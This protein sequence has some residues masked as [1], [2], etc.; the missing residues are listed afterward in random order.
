MFVSIVIPTYNRLE[1][2]KRAIASIEAQTYTNYELIIVDDASD[3]GTREYLLEL[4]HDAIVLSENQGVSHAR[5]RGAGL[6]QGE[7]IAFLDSDDCWHE[8]KLKEQVAFH[9]QNAEVKCSFG[10]E[11]WFRFKQQVKRPKKYHANEIV[12]FNDLLEFTFIGP[13]S[14]MIQ[15][16]I[17][18]SLKGFDENLRICEDFDLW[19]RLSKLTP[20]YLASAVTIYKHAGEHSQLSAS[21][22]LLE[23]SRVEALMK[24]KDDKVVQQVIKKKLEV[25]KKG[26]EKHQNREMLG[27]CLLKLKE[28]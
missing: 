10:Q 20:M 6:A 4:E 15:R 14:I 2:L 9:K 19:L 3:D 16:D 21:V 12:F 1:L 13:S 27:F 18:H 22:L 7:C 5:N 23:P 24:H 25:I 8:D 26:A 28:L 11:Q 17:F